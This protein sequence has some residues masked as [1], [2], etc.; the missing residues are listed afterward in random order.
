VCDTDKQPSRKIIFSEIWNS[1][2]IQ[3]WTLDVQGKS[4]RCAKVHNPAVL[5]KTGSNSWNKLAGIQRLEIEDPEATQTTIPKQLV[6]ELRSLESLSVTWT[7]IKSLPPALFQLPLNSLYLQ[8]NHIKSL[9]GI[10]KASDLTILDISNNR[11]DCLPKTFGELQSL[12]TLNLSG[13]GLHELPESIGSLSQLKTLDCSCNK[14]KALP[15]SLGN[16]IELTS[17][18]VSTNQLTGLPESIGFLPKLEDLRVRSN[19]LASLPDSFGQ[20][21]RLNSLLLRNNKFTDVPAQLSSL[22]NLQ[23]LNMRENMIEHVDRPIDPL[24]YL[25][26]DQNHLKQIDVGILQCPNLQYLSL[27]SNN[28]VEVTGSISKL[29]NIRSLNLSDNAISEVPSGLA[30]LPLLRHL[31][32]CSTNIRT[33][34]LAVAEMPSL[35][36]LELEDCSD[37]ENYLNIAYKTN[38]LTG[39]VDFLKGKANARSN[40]VSIYP[41]LG[42]DSSPTAAESTPPLRIKA[43]MSVIPET[44]ATAMALKATSPKSETSRI[45]EVH[46]IRRD[47]SQVPERPTKT[48]SLMP[49]DEVLRNASRKTAAE[50]RIVAGLSIVPGTSVAPPSSESMLQVDSGSNAAPKLVHMA[51]QSIC[52][53]ERP[54][55]P[56]KPAGLGEHQNP[57]TVTS[58]AVESA[59]Q[60]PV[61]TQSTSKLE[62]VVESPTGTS[63]SAVTPIA[64]MPQFGDLISSSTTD[65]SQQQQSSHDNGRD[66]T[67]ATSVTK[68]RTAP[69]PPGAVHTSTSGAASASAA[70]KPRPPV[71]KK[72]SVNAM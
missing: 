67:T 32:L 45:E 8:R 29:A 70:A 69:K 19:Q 17:L 44:P 33:L 25:I 61:P 43:G 22:T 31:S 6:T 16:V 14:L 54:A 48:E 50:L 63:D 56:Q 23:S 60:L 34:P 13:N 52:P 3:I 53:T 42:G 38:G 55:K 21:N 40:V 1:E 68:K 59:S 2:D 20:L 64:T 10:E 30:R 9:N 27:K 72:P 46:S 66:S 58:G 26:L 47:R 41:D 35:K 65:N 18:D 5:T 15:N 4:I 62:M 51:R 24:K 37:L 39:V 36:T 11:L 28:L 7:K 57:R 71:K 12:V 49:A